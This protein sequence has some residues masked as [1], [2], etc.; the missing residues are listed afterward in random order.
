[1]GARSGTKNTADHP[2]A[3]QN[4]QSSSEKKRA[5]RGEFVVAPLPISSPALGTGI[6]PFLGYIFPFST[7]DKISPPSVVGGAGLVTDNGSAAFVVAGDFI[8]AKTRIMR[9]RPIF[10]AI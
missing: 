2:D 9:R 8:L 7:R 3:P 5:H 10:A 1:V 6:I 4:Q